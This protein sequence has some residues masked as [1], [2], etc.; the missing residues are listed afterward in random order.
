MPRTLRVK[1]PGAMYHVMDQGDCQEAIFMAIFI[2]DLYRH[3]QPK[4]LPEAC[5]KTVW[6]PEN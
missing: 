2:H 3:D 4:T 6:E 1:Y 5:F